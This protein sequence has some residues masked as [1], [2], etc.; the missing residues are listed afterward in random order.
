VVALAVGPAVVVALVRLRGR[1]WLALSPVLAALLL[2]DVSGLSKAEVERIWLPFY[3]WLTLATLA[4]VTLQVNARRVHLAFQ[5]ATASMKEVTPHIA[6][7]STPP[8][9]RIGRSMKL[10]QQ[11]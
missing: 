10:F 1:P 3:P 8:G 11:S 2:A 7:Y 4:F 6:M 5:A 9:S